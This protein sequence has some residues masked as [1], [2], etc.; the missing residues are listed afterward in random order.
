MRK[1]KLLAL[2][3]TGALAG[4]AGDG[5][6]LD[7]NGR[8]EGESSG[9]LQPTFQSIQANVFTP[10]CTGCHAGAA[11]PLGLRLEEGASYALLVN[12]PS[13]EVPELRRVQP[14][15]PNASYLIQKLE[16]TAARGG[17]MPL[18]QPALPAET[19]AVIRQWIAD[20]APNTS[21]VG[22]SAKSRFEFVKLTAVSPARDETVPSPVRDIVITANVEL[23]TS[24]LQSNLIELRASGGDGNFDSG[25]ERA[26]PVDSAIRSDLPTV[27][28]I[29][30]RLVPLA[31]DFYELR[32]S[33]TDPV[34]LAD[35][36]ARPIDGDDDGA[37]G[38]DFVLRFT[39]E[40]T[41]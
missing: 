4:C 37:P 11:A 5:A 41:R 21:T 36:Q 10:V 13:V 14:G 6:G 32:I 35:L 20:G 25:N 16:G 38:G 26:V 24:L 31:A 3:M 28:A 18:N 34:A 12:A 27:L 1:A 39:V 17:R 15:N 8:P 22:G 7:E 2:C 9:S 19:I 23:D 40:M 29:T 30:P 33:G